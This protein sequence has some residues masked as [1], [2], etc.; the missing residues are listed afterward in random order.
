MDVHFDMEPRVVKANPNVEADR[1]RVAIERGPIVYCAEW[2]DN[3]GF[4]ISGVIINQNPKFEVKNATLS[5]VNPDAKYP[6]VEPHHRCSG[7]Q[8]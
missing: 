1:G 4:D 2:P 5:T 8:I 7:T 6:I 3:K